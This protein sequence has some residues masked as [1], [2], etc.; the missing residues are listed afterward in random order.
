MLRLAKDEGRAHVVLVPA[1]LGKEPMFYTIALIFAPDRKSYA[2]R[3]RRHIRDKPALVAPRI[4]RIGIAG[5]GEHYL[6]A[7]RN[8]WARSLLCVV[9]GC[10]LGRITP[11]AVADYLARLNNE[12]HLGVRDNSVG[13]RCIVAW[14]H[15]KGGAHNGGG[16]N[17]FYTGKTRDTSSSDLP[18]IGC[19]MDIRALYRVSMPRWVKTFEAMRAGEPVPQANSD[20]IN[21]ELARLPDK[22]DENL[23]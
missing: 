11:H 19:G 20:E 12:V 15:R 17:Q 13:P 3:C 5:C 18:I 9:R 21:A 7:R 14:R 8:E 2:F 1:F 22:P 10:D 6:L 16:A 23:R 4:P